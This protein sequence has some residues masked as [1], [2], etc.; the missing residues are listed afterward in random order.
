MEKSPQGG[1]RDD[2]PEFS[3]KRVVGWEE[4]QP[5]RIREEEEGMRL[6]EINLYMWGWKLGGERGAEEFPV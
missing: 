4:G 3:W 2:N 1:R 6:M 5:S